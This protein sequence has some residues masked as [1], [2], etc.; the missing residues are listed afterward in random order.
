MTL[1]KSTTICHTIESTVD[2]TFGSRKI[3]GELD[4]GTFIIA[5][6]CSLPPPYIML[7]RCTM[8]LSAR[9]GSIRKMFSTYYDSQ[10]GLHVA[11]HNEDEISAYGLAD[12]PGGSIESLLSVGFAG[13]VLPESAALSKVYSTLPSDFHI[14]TPADTSSVTPSSDNVH[15]MLDYNVLDDDD[16]KSLQQES[17]V[18][19]EDRST[20]LAL[21]DESN[22]DEDPIAVANEVA[23]MMDATNDGINH[24]CLLPPASQDAEQVWSLAEELVYLDVPGPTIKS[25]LIVD[26]AASA[27]K[28]ETMEEC[29][30]MGVNKFI[31]DASDLAW[32]EST[33]E[34]NGK[35]W[36]RRS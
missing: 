35:T 33:I 18:A 21:R 2:T 34:E 8:M 9:R 25:R 11:Q 15:L 20:C 10:S 1:L 26:L 31:V 6:S 7:G 5:A 17:L 4:R 19:F 12:E 28:D 36:K 32:F 3:D 24:I 29:L 16:V 27:D 23:S 13:I 14:F 22:Y 30:R